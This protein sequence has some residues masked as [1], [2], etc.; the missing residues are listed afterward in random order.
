[1]AEVMVR[2]IKREI[3]SRKFDQLKPSFGKRMIHR[4]KID[5]VTNRPS[6]RIVYQPI[7]CLK[8]VPLKKMPQDILENVRWWYVDKDTGEAV[9]QDQDYKELLR[10]YDPLHLVN[11]SRS[12]L[13]KLNE[14][15]LLCMDIW[16]DEAHKYKRVVR[17]C[18]K[19]GLYAGSN[20]YKRELA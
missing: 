3:L 17:L 16:K 10:V 5:P 2:I 6:V 20:L 9:M 12:D 13:L 7:K 19:K 14:L 1:M 15:R 18:V 11:L 4:R 8:K